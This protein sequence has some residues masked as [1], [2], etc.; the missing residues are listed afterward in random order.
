[1]A[2]YHGKDTYFAVEDSA[3]STL[4]AIGVNLTSSSLNWSNDQHDTTTYGQTGHTFVAG[5]TNATIDLAGFWDD[6]ASTGS[7]TVLDSLV[8]LLST[9]VAWEWGPEGNGSGDVKYS[10]E[11]ILVNVNHSAPVADLVTF[12][13][14]L[15]VSGAVTKGTFGA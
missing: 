14:Q 2:T 15:Q 10:G 13:A 9:T 3:A 6:T 1:M 7:A 4:R 12:T 11:A 5:L 8:G